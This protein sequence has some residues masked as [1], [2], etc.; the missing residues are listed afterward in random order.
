[1]FHVPKLFSVLATFWRLHQ[2]DFLLIAVLSLDSYWRSDTCIHDRFHFEE[3]AAHINCITYNESDIVRVTISIH[4]WMFLL[5]INSNSQPGHPRFLRWPSISKSDEVPKLSSS[6]VLLRLEGSI[7][8]GRLREEAGT[9]RTLSCMKVSDRHPWNCKRLS[10]DV[11]SYQGYI[12]IKVT[13]NPY[14]HFVAWKHKKS[15]LQ[16]VF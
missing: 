3:T 15:F 13:L 4:A 9:Q 8:Y 11:D 5:I 7:V 10:Q 6:M 14:R 2:L 12:V 1:M 16:H